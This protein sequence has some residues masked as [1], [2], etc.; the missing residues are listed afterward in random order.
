[1]RRHLGDLGADGLDVGQ[2]FGVGVLRARRLR[3]AIRLDRPIVDA[4]GELAQ[5]VGEAADGLAQQLR[6]GGADVDQR[7][8]P[9][10]AA[11]SPS[12]ADAPQRVDRQLLQERLDRVRADHGQAVGFFQPDAIFARNLL[13][14][15]PADEVRPGVVADAG[16]KP[17]FAPRCRTYRPHALSVTRIASSSEQRFDSGVSSRKM[18][19]TA[20]DSRLV[21][22]RIGRDD[23][24]TGR[25]EPPCIRQS[26]R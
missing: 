22:R 25:A 16:F 1:V 7:S 14:A 20:F 12:P 21:A 19:K 15:T 24:T 6:I 4:V 11:S 23:H 9:A 10:R 5:P 17:A 26:P 2:V 8:I 13:G 3:L 18:V